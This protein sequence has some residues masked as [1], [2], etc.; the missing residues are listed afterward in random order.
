MK[1]L[2]CPQWG[3]LDRGCRSAECRRKKQDLQLAN[4]LNNKAQKNNSKDQETRAV[5]GRLEHSYPALV[6]P[7][8]LAATPP[9]E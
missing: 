5:Q 3:P 8:D 6:L 7:I 1:F 9:S 2:K 4:I